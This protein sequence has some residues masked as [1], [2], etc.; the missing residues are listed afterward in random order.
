[1]ASKKSLDRDA[2]LMLI[3]DANDYGLIPKDADKLQ[4]KFLHVGNREK[5]LY[6]CE[7]LKPTDIVATMGAEGIACA[8]MLDKTLTECKAILDRVN[9]L[10]EFNK[11]GFQLK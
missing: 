7:H 2:V 10:P 1:M 8:V 3:E 4:I 9:S 6:V 5:M 11:P